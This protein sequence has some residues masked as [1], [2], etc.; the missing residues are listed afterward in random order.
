MHLQVAI[1]QPAGD[2]APM[3]ESPS[4]PPAIDQPSAG[5]RSCRPTIRCIAADQ[6]ARSYSRG[7]GLWSHAYVTAGG[8]ATATIV[9]P[10]SARSMIN[11]FILS[12]LLSLKPVNRKMLPGFGTAR[13]EV[14]R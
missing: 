8:V 2:V 13:Q 1:S 9:N 7:Q 5:S 14:V 6:F 11:F 12:P 10:M 3:A 4:A